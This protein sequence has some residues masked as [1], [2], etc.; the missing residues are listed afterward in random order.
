MQSK[1]WYKSRTIIAGIVAV[2]CIIFPEI[3]SEQLEEITTEIMGIVAILYAI[4]G[5]I[6]ATSTLT[7]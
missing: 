2:L 7:K 3:A 1:P 5:R 4:Y 6:I